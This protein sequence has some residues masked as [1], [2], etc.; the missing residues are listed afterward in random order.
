MLHNSGFIY[1]PFAVFD[2]GTLVVLFFTFCYA[3]FD[4]APGIFPVQRKSDHSVTFAVD[5]PV[6][7]I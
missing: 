1:C 6:Q 2:I 5:T 4:F 3:D 7:G